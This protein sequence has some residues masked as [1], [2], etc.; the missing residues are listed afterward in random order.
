MTTAILGR[1][2]LQVGRIGLGSSYGI[3]GAD[4]ERAF[5]RGINYLYWGTRR[6]GGFGRAIRDLA[7]R[8]REQMVVV[9]QSYTR[10]GMTLRPS[11]ELALRRLDLDH[12]DILLLGWWNAPPPDRIVDAALALREA[13]RVRHLMISCHHR[14]TFERYIAD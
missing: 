1:T 7:R 12:A 8:H 6:T 14:P 5:E 2:G 11:V 3:G 10:A 4:V 9:V 13:G